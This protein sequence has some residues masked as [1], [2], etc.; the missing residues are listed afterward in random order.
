MPAPTEAL[1]AAM[2]EEVAEDSEGDV[3]T[4]NWDI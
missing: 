4:P 2:D 3:E 1:D